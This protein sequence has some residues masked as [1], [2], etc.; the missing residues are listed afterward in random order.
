[1]ELYN[2]GYVYL[3]DGICEELQKQFSRTPIVYLDRRKLVRQ[4]IK[5]SHSDFSIEF[6]GFDNF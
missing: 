4:E 3:F 6:G 5:V 2:F 1:M